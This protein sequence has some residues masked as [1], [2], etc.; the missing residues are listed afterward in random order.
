LIFSLAHVPVYLDGPEKVVANLMETG[1]GLF[2]NQMFRLSPMFRV[3]YS[4]KIL[5]GSYRY[6]GSCQMKSLTTVHEFYKDRA[7]PLSGSIQVALALKTTTSPMS[8]P[9]AL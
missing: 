2:S 4:T 3:L 8:F 9:P 7:K 5:R 1:D 6:W